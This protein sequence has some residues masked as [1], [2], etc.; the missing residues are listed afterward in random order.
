T[1]NIAI[2]GPGKIAANQL[3]PALTQVKNVRFWSVMS[4][5]RQRASEFAKVHKAQSPNPAFIDIKTLLADPELDAVIV[6]TPDKL[7]AEQAIACATAGKHV[8]VEKPMATDIESAKAMN[9]ACRKAGVHL[10][11]GYHLRWHD[12]HRRLIEIIR[13][14]KLG[15]LRHMRVQWTS[16]AIDASNW[17]ASPE[18]GRWWSLAGVGTH[19]LDFIRWVM[20][21][22]CGEVV[23][24]RSLIANSVWQGP[25]DETA[26]VSMQ[27][28]SGA[29]AEFCS[30]VLFQSPY[31][32]EIFGES[33]YAV[34]DGTLGPKGAGNV[35]INDE[36]LEFRHL[37]P[38]VGEIKDFAAAI[39]DGR[40]PEVD[41]TEG[42]RNVELLLAATEL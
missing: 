24:I 26:L 31:R 2:I 36:T 3:A 16:K 11:V 7:H 37:N 1:I 20:V 13:A 29:T 9:D 14:G 12:G 39:E 4:R 27:F 34:C 32:A 6:A 35:C 25:H 38:Y 22:A 40:P 17:R 33:G 15:E 42:L 23:S 41:G 19:C 18:L 5:D 10:A 8:L 30:S 28:K 21:P